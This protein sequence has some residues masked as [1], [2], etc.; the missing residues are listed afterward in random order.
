MIYARQTGYPRI[1]LIGGRRM[2][3]KP[4][5][6]YSEAGQSITLSAGPDDHMITVLKKHPKGMLG[7]YQVSLS[8]PVLAQFLGGDL[9]TDVNGRLEG[10]GLDY[11]TVLNV[12]YRLYEKKAINA[13]MRWEEPSVEELIGALEP[14][15]RPESEL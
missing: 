1:A 4:P 12:L 9:R 5:V 14:M 6:L 2:V 8:V 10:L 15:G 7:P 3:C 11:A 13:T